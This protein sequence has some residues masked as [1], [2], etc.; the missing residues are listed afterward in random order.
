M[1]HYKMELILTTTIIIVS[2]AVNLVTLQ[3]FFKFITLYGHR[4]RWTWLAVTF[5]DT[6]IEPSEEDCSEVE[7]AKDADDMDLLSEDENED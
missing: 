1:P 4:T 3:R 6:Y 7:E 5:P 2:H